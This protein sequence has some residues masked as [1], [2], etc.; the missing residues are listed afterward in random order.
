MAATSWA[1]S[2]QI[3]LTFIKTSSCCNYGNFPIYFIVIN[4]NK[5]THQNKSLVCVNLL[6]NKP[7]SDPDLSHLKL[8]FRDYPGSSANRGT[9]LLFHLF[10]LLWWNQHFGTYMVLV[11]ASFWTLRTTVLSGELAHTS[12]TRSGRTLFK[13]QH[14]QV[15]KV[16][17]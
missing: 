11:L 6:D 12:L 1:S 2:V 13:Q 4:K 16:D 15:L 7:D 8:C 10:V 9:C 14:V 17:G 5:N 3:V